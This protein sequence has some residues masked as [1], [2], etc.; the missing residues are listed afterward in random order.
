MS[1]DLQRVSKE[2]RT[3]K[4]IDRRLLDE[5]SSKARTS[6]RLRTHHNFHESLKE[7]CQRLVIAM[8]PGSYLQPHRH[9]LYVKPELFVV[10]RGLVAVLIFSDAG[11]MVGAHALSPDGGTLGFEVPPGVW[12]SAISLKEDSAFMEVKPGPFHPIPPEDQA[13]WAPAEGASGA[14]SYLEKIS[15]EARHLCGI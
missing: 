11:D 5:L 14:G 7:S 13:P 9:L 10:L 3:V 8:E 4:V 1:F 6:P 12:H 15:A 2:L